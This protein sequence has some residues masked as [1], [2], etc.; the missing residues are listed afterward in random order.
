NI[1]KMIF[2]KGEV[3]SGKIGTEEKYKGDYFCLGRETDSFNVVSGRPSGVWHCPLW[4]SLTNKGATKTSSSIQ[5]FDGLV[6][7]V[8]DWPS[9]PHQ[10]KN[11]NCQFCL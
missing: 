2:E 8:L 5:T 6:E 1:Q 7:L 11:C 4:R 9:A 3:E 10:W